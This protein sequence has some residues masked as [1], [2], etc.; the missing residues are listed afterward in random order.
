MTMSSSKPFILTNMAF[1]QSRTW[2]ER[3]ES[4][5][6][7][8]KDESPDRLGALCQ[9]WR[10]FRRRKGA[11]AVVTMSPRASLA[12]GVLCGL[13]GV[14]S[15]QVLCEVFLDE[16]R[17]DSFVW[18]I[19]TALFRWVAGRSLGVIVNSTGEQARVAERFG[20][21]SERVRF[22]P[23]C[24]TVDEPRF[25]ASTPGSGVVTA[26]R[27]ARDLETYWAAARLLSDVPFVAIV[28]AGQQ[29]PAGDL[30][31]NMQ[32]VRECSWKECMERMGRAEV[33]AL[34][35]LPSERS[36]GQ[37]VL[38]EAMALGKAVVTTRMTGTVDYVQDGV[39]GVFTKAGDAPGLAAALK[40]LL[41]SPEERERIGRAALAFVEAELGPERHAKRRIE[42]V[43]AL[44]T[45]R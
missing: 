36:T 39:T 6:D 38:L 32:V 37:V 17:S 11:T 24:T 9:A 12:Y 2:R 3:T 26:G 18:R 30:P 28:G 7:P 29:L 13:L 41:A 22:V 23:L 35:L 44:A 15:R 4:I 20:I 31:A 19:K 43:E 16:E 34:P 45:K 40:R 5:C 25:V 42:A 10:L 33:V 21:P 1:W 14:E 27:T 8:E